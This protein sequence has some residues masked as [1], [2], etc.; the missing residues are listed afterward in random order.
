MNVTQP[1][2]VL[3]ARAAETGAFA[4]HVLGLGVMA[5]IASAVG[6]PNRRVRREAETSSWAERHT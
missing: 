6:Q 4:N 2:D 3:T 1:S 5:V